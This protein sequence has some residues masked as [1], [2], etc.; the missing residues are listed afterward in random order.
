MKIS[1]YYAVL[2]VSLTVNLL[3]KGTK[4]IIPDTKKITKK[5]SVLWDENRSFIGDNRVEELIVFNYY[6]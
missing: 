2:L 4:K 5:E 3:V 1:F 6:I